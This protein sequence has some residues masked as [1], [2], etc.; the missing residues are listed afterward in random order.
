LVAAT[1]HYRCRSALLSLSLSRCSFVD[2]DFYS[3]MLVRWERA[4][5]LQPLD[6]PRV[7]G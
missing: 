7:A 3:F 1:E 4:P 6:L 2:L 5:M